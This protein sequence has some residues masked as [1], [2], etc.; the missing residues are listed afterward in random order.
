MARLEY[1][2]LHDPSELICHYEGIPLEELLVRNSS[3]W[4]IREGTAYERHH[5]E[6]QDEV[7]LI[8]VTPSDQAAEPSEPAANS[9]EA[10]LVE[11]RQFEETL[12]DYP[13][14]H[15]QHCGSLLD[16]LLLLQTDTV[17]LDGQKWIKSSFE[18]DEDRKM[19]VYYAR[20]T[21]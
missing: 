4:L 18:V 3:D 20:H 5:T 7:H 15:L 6:K 9:A 10:F 1:R 8:Y 21:Q 13:L 19:F 12:T 14:L 11:I 16:V 2:L 17:T